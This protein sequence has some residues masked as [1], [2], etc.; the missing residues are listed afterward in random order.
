VFKPAETTP[1]KMLVL[2]SVPDPEAKSF[3]E[4]VGKT[5]EILGKIA[6]FLIIVIPPA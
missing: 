3:T 4:M 6:A 2:A 5:L 1:S